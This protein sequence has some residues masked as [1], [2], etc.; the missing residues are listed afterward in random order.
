MTGSKRAGYIAQY[1]ELNT[2]EAYTRGSG[3]NGAVECSNGAQSNAEGFWPLMFAA[4]NID[5]NYSQAYS[6]DCAVI[7]LPIAPSLVGCRH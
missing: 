6:W 2:R 4:G 1:Y 3:Q 7:Y 5:V